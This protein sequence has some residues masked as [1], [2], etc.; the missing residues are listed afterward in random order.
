LV[1]LLAV[2]GVALLIVPFLVWAFVK[3]LQPPTREPEAIAVDLPS[4]GG[5]QMLVSERYHLRGRPDELRRARDGRVVPVEIKSSRS[6]RSS[7]Y[8][9]HRVQALAYCLLVEEACGVPPPYTVVKY[10]DG[11]EFQVAWT[12]GTKAEILDLLE[13]WRAPYMGE[14]APARGKCSSCGFR[15][16]C[17]G[18]VSVGAAA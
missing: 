6:P 12:P 7:P 16:A 2:V 13:R 15:A 17:P 10:S 14:T 5:M 1:D 3:V 9:S 4:A 8:P 18:A 11:T